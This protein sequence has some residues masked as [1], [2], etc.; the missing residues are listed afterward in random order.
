MI[1]QKELPLGITLK[2]EA[3]NGNTTRYALEAVADV[4]KTYQYPRV[5]Q[6][7][8]DKFWRATIL[9]SQDRLPND[10]P[11][12]NMNTMLRRRLVDSSTVRGELESVTISIHSRCPRKWAFVDME[13]G[14]VWV[15][16]SRLPSPGTN[17][18]TFGLADKS[19]L[20]CLGII[21]K[22]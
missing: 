3:T 15:H 11:K 8:Q 2:V 7:I 4:L 16:K 21:L 22:I 13:T 9:E 5:G 17:L 20:N 6:V 12:I 14:Q 1:T 10:W 18:F 19:A